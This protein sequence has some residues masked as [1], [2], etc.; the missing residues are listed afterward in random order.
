[1]AEL[2]ELNNAT[3]KALLVDRAYT[4]KIAKQQQIMK[5]RVAEAA[6]AATCF[7]VFF[8]KDQSYGDWILSSLTSFD[9]GK[10]LFVENNQWLAVFQPTSMQTPPFYLIQSQSQSK[11]Y[12]VG[13]LEEKE[14]FTQD[15]GEAL[16]ETNGQESF[17][18][19]HIKKLLEA[20]VKND[21]QSNQFSKKLDEM[22]LL[23]SIDLQL[24]YQDETVQT[25]NGLHTIN[26]DALH[27]LSEEKTLELSK[28]GY[29]LPI[30]AM[31]ISLF[32]LNSLVRKNNESAEFKQIKQI[33][34]ALVKDRVTA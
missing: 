19:T 29:L 8:T 20:D 13:I 14:A 21:Y 30:H 24:H 6:K 32:Q 4:I 33:K 23:N 7:P 2:V 26:E 12:T 18:L 5:L 16:Y 3:H 22:G 11:G 1:M 28:L 15:D 10:N 9:S 27:A 31:L 25:L 34:I 17:Y